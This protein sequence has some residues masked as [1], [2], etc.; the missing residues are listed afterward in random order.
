MEQELSARFL[1]LRKQYIEGQFGKLNPVQREAVFYTEGPLLILA[2]AG[3]GKT[4]VLVNRI[5]NLVRFGGAYH[6]AL[7]PAGLTGAHVAELERLVQ[8][9]GAPSEALAPMLAQQ[10][11][12]PYRILAITFTNKA[13]GELKNRLASMLG[14]AG[15]DVNASTFHSACV[16][17]LRRECEHLGIPKSFTIYDTDDAQRAM[18]EVYRALEVD[19]K[20]LPVKTALNAIGRLKDRMVSPSMAAQ[21]AASTRDSLVAKVYSAYEARLQSAGALDFDGLIYQ[22][23][24]LLSEHADV[25]EDYQRRFRYV[26]V[27]EY[28]DTSVAQ[29]ELVRLL[30]GP[31]QNVCV[32]GDD[33]QS[34]YKF[35]GATI[36]NILSFERQ[37]P[38]AKVIRLEQNYRSTACILDAANAVIENN[39][40][41]KGK[42]LWTD[43]KGGD[44]IVKLLCDNEQEEAAFMTEKIVEAAAAGRKFS[45]FAVL[46]RVNAQASAIE[47][48][49]VKAGVPYRILAGLRF[50]EHKEVKDML[51]YL[52]VVNNHADTVRLRRIINEPKRQIGDA[53][54]ATAMEIA[55]QENLPLFDVI[56]QADRFAAFSRSAPRLTAFARMIREFEEEMEILPL[57]D[58]YKHML[59]RTGYLS[60]LEAQG[61]EAQSRIENI[62]E[63]ASAIMTYED[64]NEQPTLAGFLE[65]I[66]LMTD[67]D[68]YDSSADAVTLMTLHAAKGLEFPVVFIPGMEEGIFPGMQAIYNPDQIEEER[69]LAYVGITRA[70]EQLYLS[71]CCSRMLYGSTARNKVSRF[72]EEIPEEL[73]ECIEKVTMRRPAAERVRQP[74][75][76]KQAFAIAANAA[77]RVGTGSDNSAHMTKKALFSVGDRVSH[78]AF[79]PGMVISVKPVGNDTLVEVAFDQVGTKK[80]MANFARLTRQ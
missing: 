37:Y 4:T 56:E 52:S 21:S 51:A 45:E 69:R 64:E 72:S 11:V 29:F 39:K 40:E 76:R 17:I 28:Q 38:D 55:A 71:S 59:E 47:R 54:V 70:K 6:S 10:P 7:V 22:T 57:H 53:T 60:M 73:V 5:A 62:N 79:G 15:Q 30:T 48:A 42:N 23:V 61:E 14:Q 35:R 49:F 19:D 20:F 75:E 27:D 43:K 3:S 24:K 12:W 66:S 46:Y 9:G 67:V 25:R 74:D 8:A 1:A 18:K 80:L 2:G 32:V 13:A 77:R 41:R 78:K 26:L 65:E 16:R 31:G 68:N 36:E 33:D 63:L 58:V 34:I 44:K 50:Y